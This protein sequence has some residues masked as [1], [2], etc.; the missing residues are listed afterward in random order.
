MKGKDGMVRT[1]K[2]GTAQGITNHPI[3]RLKPLEAPS[4]VTNSSS[5]DEAN[6][7]QLER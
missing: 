5:T 6:T 3:I 1:A 2:I 7:I 4:D